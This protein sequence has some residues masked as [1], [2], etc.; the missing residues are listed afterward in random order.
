MSLAQ[1]VHGLAY[2]SGAGFVE[3]AHHR[4]LT[5]RA[6]IAGIV[7][8]IAANSPATGLTAWAWCIRGTYAFLTIRSRCLAD[9]ATSSAVVRVG[10]HASACAVAVDRAVDAGVNAL[11]TQTRS[12]L[13]W[14]RR[15]AHEIA[16]PAVGNV[17]GHIRADITVAARATETIAVAVAAAVAAGGQASVLLFL[18]C[19]SAEGFARVPS[20]PNDLRSQWAKDSAGN[21]SPQQTQRLAARNR[22]FGQGF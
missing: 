20:G 18:V 21:S 5:S 22:V 1:L 11:A 17:A 7:V 14:A 2:T 16:C 19:T 10:K 15:L 13:V 8:E 9:M 3:A 12:L 6:A 4:I